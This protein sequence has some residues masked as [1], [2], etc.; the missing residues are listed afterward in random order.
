[1]NPWRINP[2]QGILSADGTTLVF[3]GG[4][5]RVGSISPSQIDQGGATP[6]QVLAWSGSAWAPAAAGG[7]SGTTVEVDLGSTPRTSGRFTITDAAIA[8][9][10]K[11]MAWQA[12]GPYTGKGTLADEA[13][14]QPVSVIAVVP[15]SGS[16]VVHWETPPIIVAAPV[17]PNGRRDAPSTVAG[18]NPRYPTVAFETK[19]I[20]KVSGNV[21]FSYM[22]L[23]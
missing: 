15:A 9:T 21:K 5:A 22:I 1:M 16:C 14:M 8:G 6:A 23:A 20:G 13:A 3:T 17:T 18:F 7:A 4:M 2:Q 19:R 12:P 11:V 10:S